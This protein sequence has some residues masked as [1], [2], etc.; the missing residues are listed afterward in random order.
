[1][2]HTRTLL[3]ALLLASPGALHA[4]EH[5]LSPETQR[6]EFIRA[7]DTLRENSLRKDDAF[8]RDSD[9]HFHVAALAAA[10]EMRAWLWTKDERYAL[11]ALERMRFLSAKADQIREADFFTPLPLAFAYRTADNAKLVD[12]ELRAAMEKFVALRFKPR[13]FDALNNQT[14]TRACGL[15]LA[16]QIWPHLPPARKWHDYAL[17]IAA[18]LEKIEDVPENAPGYNALDVVCLWVLADLL[19]KPELTAHPGIVAMYRRYRDQISPAGFLAPYGDAG[20]APQPFDADWPMTS[21]WAHYVAAFERAAREYRD[22]T[23]RWA[24]ARMAR[25]G[26]DHMP[27]GRGYTDIESL[28]YGGFAVDWIDATRAQEQPRLGSQLLKRRDATATDVFDKLILAP[29][30]DDGAPF[31][32]TDLYCRGAHGHLNQHGAVTYFEFRGTPLLTSLGYNSREPAHANLLFIGFD[33]EPFPHQPDA[34]TPGVWHKASLPTSRL[35]PHDQAQPFLR[36]V[37]ALNFR[38]TAG[39]NGVIFTAANVQLG[40]GTQP[41]IVLDDLH[42]A[43]GWRGKPTASAEG[44]VWSVAK[45]VQFLEKKGFN[46]VFDCRAY[47]VLKF[48]WKLS[49]NDEKSRPIILRV[50]CGERTVDYHAHA[51]Q[52]DPTLVSASVE[53]RDGVQRG[54]LHYT[55]WFTPD[56]T[57]RR[58]MALTKSGVLVVRDTLVP[59]AAARGMVAGPLW[60][61]ASTSAPVAGTNWFNSA[62]GRVELLAWFAPAPTRSVGT[63]CVNVWSKDNQQ[64]V[65]ARQSL[66]PGKPVEFLSVL[67]PHERSTDAAQ[68]AAQVSLQTSEGGRVRVNIGGDTIEFHT[69]SISP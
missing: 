4:E 40:G 14:L 30:R 16:S 34:F 49:N 39:R 65:F 67:I 21:A 7:L 68:L 5:N 50:H 51:R 18:M 1:M 23:L 17:T 46:T 43:N 58:E 33:G 57:L 64:T 28:F 11:S 13:D 41:T 53:E 8:L 29:S 56:T 63:Q 22:P 47:P 45:G 66:Q 31:L 27:L 38:V 9:D 19:T 42:S 10:C 12:S 37:D 52:L 15:E 69:S 44:L 60:H 2:K 35:P 55:G 62:G 3:A 24:A 32:M 26:S 48:R 54:T 20:G 6:T 36:R 25:A 59:G 61:V